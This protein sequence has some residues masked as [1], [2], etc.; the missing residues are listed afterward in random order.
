[1]TY[2]MTE[3]TKKVI[4]DHAWH[5]K[6]GG[7][8][9]EYATRWATNIGHTGWQTAVRS[10]RRQ[11]TIGRSYNALRGLATERQAPPHGKM[12]SDRPVGVRPRRRLRA[13]AV[14]SS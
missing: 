11:P 5:G 14:N 7:H 6:C 3:L 1:M 9:L 4:H 2:F 12:A 13:R 10:C 8:G